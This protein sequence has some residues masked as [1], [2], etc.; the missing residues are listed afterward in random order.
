MTHERRLRSVRTGADSAT[1]DVE[2]F[3]RLLKQCDPQ[4]R[5]LAYSML[6]DFDATH[7]ALQIAYLKAYRKYDSFER[8]A[9]FST[10]LYTIV[11]RTCLD[12]IR[13]R[14][15]NES[16][17]YLDQQP[18]PSL[19]PG[20]RVE[21]SMSINEALAQL[22]PAQRAAVLLV[23]GHGLSFDEAS[24][25]LGIPAGTLGSRLSRARAALRQHLQVQDLPSED[26][27]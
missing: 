14:R 3:T 4:M 20:D 22:P 23:D 6:R 5:A 18:D 17:D 26:Q 9:A 15:P 2:T 12:E 10:W 16:I 24:E 19:D 7:D 13:R 21:L 8:R 25:A 1:G 27:T 11:Y